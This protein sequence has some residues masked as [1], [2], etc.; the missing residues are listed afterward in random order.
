MIADGHSS[1]AATADGQALQQS[2]AFAGWAAFVLSSV[3]GGVQSQGLLVGLEGFPVDVAGVGVMD[4][5]GPL[6]SGELLDGHAPLGGLAA[7]ALAIGE[8][9]GVAGVV[10]GAQHSPVTQRHPGEFAL[11]WTAAHPGRERQSLVFEHLDGG[12]GRSGAGEG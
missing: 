7:P 6:L 8:R 5:D 9:S 4:E 1:S 10:Q 11:A 12:S 3:G 2:G